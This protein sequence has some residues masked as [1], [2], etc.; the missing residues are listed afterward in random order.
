MPAKYFTIDSV[1]TFVH[2]RGPTTLPGR[3]PAA[4]DGATIV[5]VHDVAGNGH[6]F[7]GVL[8]AL[9][10]A[11]RPIAFDLPAHGRSG[12]VDSL[13]AIEAMAAHARAFADRLELTSPVLLGDGMGAAVALEAAATWPDWPAAVVVCGGASVTPAPDPAAIA[14]LRQVTAGRARRQFDTTGYA[15]DTERGVYERAF[16]EWMKTD[17]RATV[18]DLEALAAWAGSERVGVISAPV[19]VVVGEHETAEARTAAETLAA[20]VRNGRVV[21]LAG[22]GRRG[23][24]EQPQRLAA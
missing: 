20:A 13:G 15:P 19:V 3:P 6:V 1:A 5:C 9:A 7:T 21:E 11:H 14:Q 8:D 12:G 24:L 22:A 23:V 17:P 10:D 4:A 2:H 16:A 18:G